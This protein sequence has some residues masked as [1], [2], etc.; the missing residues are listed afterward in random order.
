[1]FLRKVAHDNA[2]R[3]IGSGNRITIKDTWGQKTPRLALARTVARVFD[4]RVQQL[5]GATW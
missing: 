1:V 5:T 4:A 3:Q 2:R